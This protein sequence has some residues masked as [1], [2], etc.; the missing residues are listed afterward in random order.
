MSLLRLNHPSKKNDMPKLSQYIVLYGPPGAGKSTII[1]AAKELGWPAIDLEEA[2]ETYEER[3][4]AL[5]K[6]Q[7]SEEFTLF[8]AADLKPED[9]SKDTK[10]VLLLPPVEILAKRV[11]ER[12]D[13]REHKGLEHALKVWLEHNEMAE[14][15]VFNLVIEDDLPSEKVLEYLV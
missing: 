10:L 11:E 9:F 8:G 12:A 15:G 7:D 13:A 6:H 14:Q 4:K 1:K 5:A 2:G 3:R